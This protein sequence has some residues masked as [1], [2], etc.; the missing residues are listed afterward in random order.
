MTSHCKPRD[1]LRSTDN[2]TRFLRLICRCSVTFAFALTAGASR[3]HAQQTQTAADRDREKG[4]LLRACQQ[5]DLL[6]DRSMQSIRDRTDCW[7]RMQLQGMGDAAVDSAYRRAVADYDAANASDSVRHE[8]E[9]VDQ[10][11]VTAQQLIERRQLDSAGATVAA[12]L[13]IQPENQRALAFRDRITALL[14]AARLRDTMFKLAAVVLIASLILGGASLALARRH[15]RALVQQ[16]AAAANQRAVIEIIDGVGRGK[17]Y[18]I[19]DAIFR[20]GSAISERPEEKNHLILSDHDEFISR[21]H[22]AVVL[23][24]G[25]YFLIDSSLNG[26]YLDDELM[27]RGEHRELEDGAEFSVAGVA[28]MKFLLM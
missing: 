23:K 4:V 8:G 11:L 21:Y 28:R 22:C 9:S 25:K 2:V 20:I 13:S 26:T 19:E 12:V 27:E 18:T 6:G 17:M 14:R 10:R 16:Q 15:R 3:V 7:K 1:A 24:H 5:L